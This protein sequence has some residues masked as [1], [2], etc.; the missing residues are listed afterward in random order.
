MGAL[1][2]KEDEVLVKALHVWESPLT[3][4]AA[5]ILHRTKDPK[6]VIIG[7]LDMGEEQRVTLS[8]LQRSIRGAEEADFGYGWM[9]E[10][11]F[12]IL[13]TVEGAEWRRKNGR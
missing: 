8:S 11:D 10:P 3:G 7:D 13:D 6:V 9:S 1:K 4:N 2:K 5:V 12:D